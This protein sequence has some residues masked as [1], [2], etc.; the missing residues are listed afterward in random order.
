MHPLSQL[1]VHGAAAAS[2]DNG[3]G[4]QRAMFEEQKGG[5]CEGRNE[6]GE[7]AHDGWMVGWLVSDRVV[8]VVVM[9]ARSLSCL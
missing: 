5:G 9:I 4:L 3:V 2:L 1:A 8:L 6:R 7:Q